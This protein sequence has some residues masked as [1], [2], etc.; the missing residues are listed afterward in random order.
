M[1]S[2]CRISR[3]G[4]PM[5]LRTSKSMNIFRFPIKMSL[6]ILWKS[7][8]GRLSHLVTFFSTIHSDANWYNFSCLSSSEKEQYTC[9]SVLPTLPFQKGLKLICRFLSKLFLKKS[10]VL[11]LFIWITWQ[12]FKWQSWEHWHHFLLKMYLT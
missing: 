5:L 9:Y 3:Q 1:T 12:L 4:L 2:I 10:S 7:P 6:D 11:W 8:F